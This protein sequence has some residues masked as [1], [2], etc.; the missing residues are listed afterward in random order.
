MIFQGW[1]I[2]GKLTIVNH[3]GWSSLLHLLRPSFFSFQSLTG[4]KTL[5]SFI[6]ESHSR[7][8]FVPFFKTHFI[9]FI[10]S[11]LLNTRS[12]YHWQG[13]P[14]KDLFC[15]N[16]SNNSR[17]WRHEDITHVLYVI[18]SFKPIYFFLIAN[19]WIISKLIIRNGWPHCFL[20]VAS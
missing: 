18:R 3:N 17:V 5:L 1:P 12:L 11:H 15:V 8:G 7:D 4:Y 6:K 13:G 2:P 9:R 10:H 14:L 16:I 19:H 20:A